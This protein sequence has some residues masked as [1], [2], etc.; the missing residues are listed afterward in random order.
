MLLVGLFGGAVAHTLPRE[1]ADGIAAL[2]CHRLMK[3]GLGQIPLS[4]V[5]QCLHVWSVQSLPTKGRV[6]EGPED[7]PGQMPAL[8]LAAVA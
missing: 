2:G 8:L 4:L 7:T 5:C 3:A 6:T 1:T